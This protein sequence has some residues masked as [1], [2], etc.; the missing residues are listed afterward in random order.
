MDMVRTLALEHMGAFFILLSINIYAANI[1]KDRSDSIQMNT[2]NKCLFSGIKKL[3][4]IIPATPS[5]LEN[6]DG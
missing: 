3:I 5:F 4:L 6:S 1:R 2:H